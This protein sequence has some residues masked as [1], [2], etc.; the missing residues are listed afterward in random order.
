VPEELVA[1]DWQHNVHA[2][3]QTHH[4]RSLDY[5]R[6]RLAG[7]TGVHILAAL[8]DPTPAAVET[9]PEGFALMGFDLVDQAV[10]V[11]ALTGCGG[12]EGVFTGEE[13]SPF[14]LLADLERASAVR[15]AL[16]AGFPGEHHAQCDVWAI[17]RLTARPR[18]R[19]AVR[20]S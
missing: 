7:E 17:W 13:L 15:E 14:G 2:D 8:R 12:W 5:L 4:F 11:S 6:R 18:R 3:Y 20:A 9:G 19:G 16:R 1:E 10:D